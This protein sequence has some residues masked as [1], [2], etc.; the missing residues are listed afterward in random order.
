M[1]THHLYLTN[2]LMVS[3]LSRGGS[4]ASRREFPATDEGFAAFE[5]YLP[6]V[7]AHAVRFFTDLAEE[8]FRADTVPHVGAKDRDTMLARKLGQIYRNAPYRHA[9]LQGR[10]TTGRRDDRVLYAAITSAE[11][12]KPWL[13]AI[14]RRE[15][16]LAG[17]HSAALLGARLLDVAD[18]RQPHVLLVHLSPG[19]A[20]RQTYFRDRELRLTRLTHVDLQEGQTL[21]ALLADETT[22][23]WQYLDNLRSFAAADRLHVVILAHPR[24]HGAIHPAL[25]GFDQ[26][27]YQLLD[28]DQVAAK[29]GLKPPPRTSSAEEILLHL[30]ERK[31]AENHFASSEMRRHWTFREARKAVSTVAAGVLALGL[32][33]GGMTLFTIMRTADGDQRTAREV[34]N[35]NREYD[36]LSRSLPSSGMGGTAM[37][38]AVTFHSRFIQNFPSIGGFVVPLSAALEAHPAVRLNQLAWQATDNPNA[39]PALT[40]QLARVPPPVKSIARGGEVAAR[41]SAPDEAT[42]SFTRG[43]FEV[44]LLEAV[45]N[46]PQHDFRSALGEVEGLVADIRKLKGYDAQV[47]ESP[48]DVRPSLALQGRNVEREPG[49]M[50]AR[51]VVRI[52]RTRQ[53]SG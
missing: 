31:P 7:A 23:T 34:M 48:L 29:I 1:A 6:D 20:L 17:M 25:Q 12:V 35:L 30:F 10:E 46:V 14:E 39:T 38:D 43:R 15:I 19:E 18:V 27:G 9:L 33:V 51:F 3:L 49:S 11:V 47:I 4:L 52:V 24:D 21:G 28:S 2:S 50:E 8:D 13:D 44:A 5:A 37:R 26:L 40:P 16:P 41:T 53:G 32:I 22:R 45:V 42:P 36:Q